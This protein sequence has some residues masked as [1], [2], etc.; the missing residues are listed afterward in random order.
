MKK[1]V[2]KSTIILISI[3]LILLGILIYGYYI[4]I[5]IKAEI[6]RLNNE[7]NLAKEEI[8]ATNEE[9]NRVINDMSIL[10]DK[11][12]LLEKDVAE[13]YKTCPY[14]N[15]CKGRFPLI[16]WYCNDK[17]D[18]SPDTANAPFICVCDADCKITLT[19]NNKV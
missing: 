8:N 11:Y 5:K 17:G 2:N 1:S 16:S 3:I 7:L 13:I 10:Q 14:E 4:G 9:K 15:A 18:Y 6:N 12:N 19:P